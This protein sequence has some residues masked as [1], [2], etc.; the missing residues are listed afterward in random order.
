[1]AKSN[2]VLS[3]RA[4]A[5]LSTLA[6]GGLLNPEQANAF[7]DLVQDE[8][9]ILKQ[10]RVER[11][12]SPQKNI[13]RMGFKGRLLHKAR[14]DP[15]G[16]GSENRALTLAERKSVTTS[17]IQLN[18]KEF[19]AEV[20]IPYEV[21]EDNIERGGFEAHIMREIARQVSMDLEELALNGDTTHPTDTYLQ[22]VDG[23]LK[24]MGGN[25]VD[26]ANAGVSPDL[27]DAGLL[28]MPQKYLRRLTELRHFIST[29]NT[30]KYRA[31]VA[32]RATGYGDS[33]LTQNIPL[34]AGGVAIEAA[35]MLTAA[36]ETSWGAGDGTSKESGFFTFP[37]N[38]IWGIQRQITMEYE[39]LISE[40]EI[41]IVVTLRCDFLIDDTDACVKYTNIG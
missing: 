40:R 20:R 31:A 38:L 2:K 9:T 26:N 22:A 19:I 30:I 10:V 8:P 21:L 15:L 41:K 17:Q 23:Y 36:G 37:K 7:I 4:D 16:N 3:K 24:Q 33:A 11:M 25:V 34:Y 5:R 6:T 27:F 12:N 32:K 29:A 35:A 13:D 18:T 39:K 28:A 14:Q 1:M